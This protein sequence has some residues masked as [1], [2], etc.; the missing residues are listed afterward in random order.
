MSD[1]QRSASFLAV[2]ALMALGAGGTALAQSGS[3]AT[4]PQS[5]SQPSSSESASS[6]Q[7]L[8]D[9]ARLNA[10]KDKPKAKKVYT[11]DDLSNLHGSISVVGEQSKGSGSADAADSSPSGSGNTN[12]Q[13]WRSRAQTI[14]QEIAETDRQIDSLKAEIAKQG[15]AS[16]DP[17]SGLAQGVIIVHDRNAQ[18]KQ[19]E[20]RKASLEH[21]L[22][23]LADEARKAGADPG[24]A[25]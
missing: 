15:P 25:R 22:D 12:E 4:P 9:A 24:W 21:Q 17:S 14:K 3:P 5:G 11:A 10:Q 16:F 19:L 1:R 13:Y 23:D 8:A 7:S 20:D 2:F 18:V 6:P